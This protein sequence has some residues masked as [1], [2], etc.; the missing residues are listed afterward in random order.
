MLN[1]IVIFYSIQ[2]CFVV[3][4]L[5]GKKRLIKYSNLKHQKTSVI[6]P[7]KNEKYRILPLLVS[8]NESLIKHKEEEFLLNFE[9]I[10]IDDHS[11]DGT[12]QV[13]LDN[14]DATYKILK[15][16]STYGKKQAIK[17]GV[18][19]SKFDRILTLDADVSFNDNYLMTLSKTDCKNLTILPVEMK[20]NSFLQKLFAIEFLFLQNLTFGL[21]GFGKYEL[22]NGSNLLFSKKTF[23]D[24]L[25]IRN[26]ANVASGDD[27]FLLKA[28]KTLRLDI[29]A[30]SNTALKVQTPVEQT[31]KEVLKQR[32]RW[33]SKTKDLQSV[34]AG[35]MLLLS[36][37][38]LLFCIYFVM[39][40]NYFF[41]IP[42]G[43][44]LISELLIIDRFNK[45]ILIL[46]HQFFY[47][48]YLLI[49]VIKLV[50]G[51]KP[52]WR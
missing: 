17:Y 2:L 52:S 31:I 49:V 22:C 16:D 43:I 36:N 1:I 20:G 29:S 32:V 48:I 10:F 6:V 27:M 39:S 51:S 9:F 15:I 18:E 38:T 3:F 33:I 40:G 11:N 13:I 37:F 46:I 26:D 44:K 24:T 47:P 4:L 45:I 5:I 50:G 34:N 14:L 23:N 19:Q 41:F 12:Y 25:K 30:V 42:I 28:T 35:L 21:A 7:F 8:I